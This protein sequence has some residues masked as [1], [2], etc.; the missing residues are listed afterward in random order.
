LRRSHPTLVMAVIASAGF[1]ARAGLASPGGRLPGLLLPTLFVSSWTHFRLRYYSQ[2]GVP[3]KP[4]AAVT[5]DAGP[6]VPAVCEAA[7]AAAP[8]LDPPTSLGS[9]QAPE[10]LAFIQGMSR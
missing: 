2:Q 7:F 6:P 3:A 9:W 4:G 1:P 5:S 10:L 8:V